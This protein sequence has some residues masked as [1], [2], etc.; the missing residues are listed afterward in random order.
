MWTRR[1]LL[2]GAVMLAAAAALPRSAAAAFPERPIRLVV[3][4]TAGGITDILARIVAAR[5]AERLGTAVVVDNRAGAGGSVGAELVARATPDGHALLFGSGGPLTANPALQAQLPYDVERDFT[6][7]GLVGITP[8]VCQVGPRLGVTTLT[9]FLAL[10]RARPGQITV[11]TP[12]NGSAA[13]LALELMMAGAD[14]RASHVP[15]RG[16]SAMMPDLIS[17]TV[18]ACLIEIPSA[19]PLHRDGKARIV[20]VA[21]T[22]RSPHLPEVQTFI[23]AGLPGYTSG[24]FGGVLAPAGTP[25]EVLAALQAA[26]LASLAEPSVQARIEEVGAILGTEAQRRPEGFAAFLRSELANARR[27]VALAG[28]KPG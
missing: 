14:A 2:G 22:E 8:M 16:G 19:L 9:D 18:D 23:E 28:L 25:P 12:G 5:M 24:S 26:L 11:A 17:G 27:A 7:I 15:Y 1:P 13:H 20:A 3:P 21:T 6:P 4:F 10:L